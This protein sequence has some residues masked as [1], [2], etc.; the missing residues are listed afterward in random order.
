MVFLG[1]H[2]S[3]SD[4][5]GDVTLLA[6]VVVDGTDVSERAAFSSRNAHTRCVYDA[7]SRERRHLPQNHPAFIAVDDCGVH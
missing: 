7:K 1:R 2:L 4:T 5:A 3:V 6:Q